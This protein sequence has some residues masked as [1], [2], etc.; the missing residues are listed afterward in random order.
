[1]STVSTF[2][3]RQSVRAC[4]MAMITQELEREQQRFVIHIQPDAPGVESDK[5]KILS[6]WVSVL[7]QCAPVGN[8]GRRALS[9]I[10]EKRD[11]CESK[12][13]TGTCMNGMM[14]G[15][16]KRK[17]EHKTKIKSVD[18]PTVRKK[19]QLRAGDTSFIILNVD[20]DVDDNYSGMLLEKRRRSRQATTDSE[21][22]GRSAGEEPKQVIAKPKGPSGLGVEEHAS[23]DLGLGEGGGQHDELRCFME[24]LKDEN[25]SMHFACPAEKATRAKEL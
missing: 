18:A 22:F 5:G 2:C 9:H 25:D 8:D 10:I 19:S 3:A 17:L 21:G 24:C 16:R 13:P 14:S 7:A 20:E 11:F 6:V 4:D 12:L 1:M 15:T 23:R